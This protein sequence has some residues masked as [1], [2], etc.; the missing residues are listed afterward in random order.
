MSQRW[1][2]NGTNICLE[3]VVTINDNETDKST[4]F[5]SIPNSIICQQRIPKLA[6]STDTL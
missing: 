4:K 1:N 3:I 6:V 2:W 5:V